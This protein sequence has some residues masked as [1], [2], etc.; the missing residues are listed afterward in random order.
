M[1][2]WPVS[3][4][5]TRD[6]EYNDFLKW[7]EH[8]NNYH[9][10][11]MDTVPSKVPNSYHSPHYQTKAH[12][13][14]TKSLSIFTQNEQDFLDQYCWL[15]QLS[16]F[17]RTEDLFCVIN[18]VE[19]ESKVEQKFQNFKLDNERIRCPDAGTLHAMIPYVKPLFRIFPQLGHKKVK[20]SSLDMR[21]IVH[22]TGI[23]LECL[24]S[25]GHS[26]TLRNMLLA[27]DTCGQTACHTAA[28][29]DNVQA[30]KEIWQWA[31]GVTP[32]LSYRLLVSQDKQSKTTW[33]LAA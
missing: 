26:I 32:T 30:L 4:G 19:A 13:K 12:D 1:V 24:K 21:Q 11:V 8:L 10:E 7:A 25:G 2:D 31:E 14:Y 3:A 33:H 16:E 9:P 27:T 17:F 23:L 20:I 28:T 18:N 22:I 29:N 6:A 15:H 5:L